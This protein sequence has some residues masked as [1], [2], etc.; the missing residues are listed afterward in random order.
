M[1][2]YTAYY[3]DWCN[4]NSVHHIKGT[5]SRK[6]IFERA[7]ETARAT[8]ETVTVKVDFGMRLEFYEVNP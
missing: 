3:G 1:A 6:E 5:Y 7:R 2:W 4:G 8:G